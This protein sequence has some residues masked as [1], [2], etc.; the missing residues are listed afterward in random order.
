MSAKRK[1]I[2]LGPAY[3]YRG[4]IA[5]FNQQLAEVF[6]EN[7]WEV[8][9]LT[10]KYLYP[11][12]LFPGKNQYVENEE[13]PDLKIKRSLHSLNPFNWKQQSKYIADKNP[14]LILGQ[15]WMPFV[16]IH[17]ASY[18]K[19]ISETNKSITRAAIVHN[20]IPHEPKPGDAFLTKY[21]TNNADYFISLSE[22]VDK[23]IHK[24]NPKLN[25][26]KLLN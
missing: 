18:F 13:A 7:N 1:A 9:L 3:P 11:S 15:Y 24:I 2:F 6:I 10:Y 17:L 21:M 20:L 8:E 16:A 5:A 23:D 19:K 14:D 4:G 25:T 26:I 12:I 22:T